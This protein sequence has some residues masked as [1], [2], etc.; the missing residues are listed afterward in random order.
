MFYRVT[1]TNPYTKKAYTLT[2]ESSAIRGL[3]YTK[4]RD[5]KQGASL[6]IEIYD[7]DSEINNDLP[8]P[9]TK[10]IPVKLETATI[11]SNNLSTVFTGIVKHKTFIEI[12]RPE[13]LTLDCHDK[14]R[15]LRRNK[16][17]ESFH[18]MTAIE[19]SRKIAKRHGLNVD[20]NTGQLSLSPRATFQQKSD[21]SD[22]DLLTM[23]IHAEGLDLYVENDTL[24]IRQLALNPYRL[25]VKVGEFPIKAFR[26]NTA[27]PAHKAGNQEK[28]VFQVNE[29]PAQ[30]GTQQAKDLS[31]QTKNSSSRLPLASPKAGNTDAHHNDLGPPQSAIAFK[32]AHQKDTANL[33]IED[34]LGDLTLDHIVTV[35]NSKNIYANGAWYI[36]TITCD[37]IQQRTSLTLKRS[38]S[39]A[40]KQKAAQF[41][42]G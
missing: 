41:Q 7:P 22:W 13:V 32:L 19:L 38:I 3:T 14:S 35:E 6:S 15:Q 18:G 10:D 30:T 29:A 26:V 11:D 25:R 33:V 9:F 36:D 1:V 2:D 21:F 27:S 20:A 24:Y 8:D 34:Y 23:A 12:P 39:T 40:A 31:Y 42:V 37:V 16:K 5:A 17:E 4:S 28:A